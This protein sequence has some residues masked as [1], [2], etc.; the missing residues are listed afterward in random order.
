MA[1]Y[2]HPGVYI[3][4][5]SSGARPIEGVSTSVTAFVGSANRGPVGEAIL[6][7]K[8]DDYADEFG[9]WP[10][11]VVTGGAMS[12]IKDD[13]G[14]VDSFVTDLAVKGIVLAYKKY[15]EEKTV[16]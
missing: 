12:V 4:E 10:Q 7:G 14:F 5:I 11:A 2:L 9:K 8:Y 13:C 1:S 6:I 16:I 15:I 3:E